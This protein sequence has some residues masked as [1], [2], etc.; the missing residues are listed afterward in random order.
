M[1]RLTRVLKILIINL[2]LLFVVIFI[3]DFICYKMLCKEFPVKHSHYYFSKFYKKITIQEE[4]K[5]RYDENNK[6]GYKDYT[7]I[8]SPMQHNINDN[9]SIII[10]G[11]SMAFGLGLNEEQT[12][13]SKLSNILNI[14]IYNRA[15]PGRGL[16]EIIY[17]FSDDNSLKK[18]KKEPKYILYFYNPDHIRRMVE[19]TTPS[20]KIDCSNLFYKKQRNKL[21]KSQLSFWEDFYFADWIKQK[22]FDKKLLFRFQNEKIFNLFE[23]HL[24][25]IS[26][27]IK[28][29][30]PNSKFIIIK[31]ADSVYPEY[32]KY[33]E[34]NFNILDLQKETGINIMKYRGEKNEYT[35]DKR[36]HPSEYYWDTVLPV[37]LKKL[38]ESK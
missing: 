18:I 11:C 31:F 6:F 14:T 16:Q 34:Y 30:Y 37:I 8:H 10:L 3:V 27:L 7:P 21:V 25:T 35:V 19:R 5:L 28:E 24:K 1:N 20:N 13:S 2:I 26:L 29:N 15:N 36:C 4:F 23:L 12:I 33:L 9:E 22:F 17:L 32:D 38:E